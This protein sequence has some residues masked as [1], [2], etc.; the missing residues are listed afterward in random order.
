MGLWEVPPINFSDGLG[1]GEV[2]YLYLCFN[3]NCPLYEGRW[4]N[5]RENYT[6]NASHRCICYPGT[7]QFE[8]MPVFSPIGAKGQIIDDQALTTAEMLKERPNAEFQ[9]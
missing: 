1:W 9:C 3:Y 4:D 7:T 5:L 6:Q 2:P 8:Y